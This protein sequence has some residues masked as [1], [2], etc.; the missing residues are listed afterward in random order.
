MS[1]YKKDPQSVINPDGTLS[2]EAITYI[3]GQGLDPDE[4]QG[5]LFK[6]FK[7]LVDEGYIPSEAAI[8]AQAAG[9]P[10]PVKLTTGQIRNDLGQMLYEDL[11]SKG[12]SAETAKN[13]MAGFFR[14]Q[15]TAIESN[16]REIARS[17]GSGIP[18]KGAADAQDLLVKQREADQL[19][20]DA[21]Y[22]TARNYQDVMLD[23]SSATTFI[24]SFTDDFVRRFHR[25]STPKTWAIIDDLTADLEK[26]VT[27]DDLFVRRAQLTSAR[28]ELGSEGK[29]AG[30]AVDELDKYFDELVKSKLFTDSGDDKAIILWKEAIDKWAGFKQRWDTNGIL[31]DL[32]EQVMRDGKLQ[33]KVAPEDAANYIFGVSALGAITKKNLNRDMEVLKDQLPEDYWNSLRGEIVTKLLDGSLTSGSLTTNVSTKLSA[34]WAK[35]RRDNKGLVDLLFN[36]EEQGL[37]SSLANVTDRIGNRTQNRSTSGDAVGNLVGR[38]YGMIGKTAPA[39]VLA[40][41]MSKIAPPLT[42]A[43]GAVR[44]TSG[45]PTPKVPSPIIIGGASSTA[46]DTENIDAIREATGDAVEKIPL[47]GPSIAPIV[48]P[49]QARVVPPAPPSRGLPWLE[50]GQQPAQQAPTPPPQALAQAPSQSSQMMEQ[51]FP[52]G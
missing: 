34:D 20:A 8:Q 32:T 27:V 44:A 45:A 49:P 25:N 1:K 43:V 39:A 19:V 51:L 3:R 17:M 12:A 50:G 24:T 46:L 42:H 30:E 23:P 40:T 2:D 16:A 5:E 29:A 21:K 18:R 37:I 10:F 35:M 48:A 11:V 52:Y 36:F 14:A 28:S 38:L 31:S 4:I 33:P 7:N 47:I 26:G 41:L 15:E 13:I 22:K 9:L 6:S